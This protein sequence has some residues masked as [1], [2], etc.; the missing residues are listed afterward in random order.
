LIRRPHVYGDWEL[1]TAGRSSPMGRD[2]KREVGAVGSPASCP[3][4]CLRSS[5]RRSC[6]GP[7]RREMG[8]PGGEAGQ[9]T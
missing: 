5:A 3:A 8:G 7:A 6:A 2:F 1:E 4:T 9:A